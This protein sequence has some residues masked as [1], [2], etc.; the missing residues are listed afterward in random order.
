MDHTRGHYTRI[1]RLS[2]RHASLL[3]VPSKRH[4]ERGDATIDVGI[5]RTYSKLMVL[6]IALPLFCPILCQSEGARPLCLSWP[7]PVLASWRSHHSSDGS[8][9]LARVFT[10]PSLRR[11]HSDQ[12]AAGGQR[13]PLK[14]PRPGPCSG[15]YARVHSSEAWP[16]PVLVGWHSHHFSSPGITTPFQFVVPHEAG[17]GTRTLEEAEVS[18]C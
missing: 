7:K 12:Q 15:G 9:V 13:P 6:S 2:L 1:A 5:R 16:E 3:C 11:L 10:R 18:R 14:V 17:E 8:L 4:P